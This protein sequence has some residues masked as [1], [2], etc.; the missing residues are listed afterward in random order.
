MSGVALALAL[1]PALRRHVRRARLLD[2]PE[3]R[4]PGRRVRDG[5]AAASPSAPRSRSIGREWGGELW[6]FVLAGLLAPGGAQLLFVLAVREAGPARASVIAGAAPLVAVTIAITALGRAAAKL[7]LVAGAVLIVAGGLA[8]I[9]ERDCARSV[10]GDRARLRVR[11]RRALRDAR[12][13]R[14]P[15]RADTTVAPQLA[16]SATILSGHGAD[17]RS[18]C[19]SRAGRGSSPTSAREGPPF[20]L[21]GLLWGASYAFLFEAFY[22]SRVIGRQP[23][24]RDGV[25]VR[26]P[27]RGAAPAPHGARRPAPDRS[28]RRWSSPAAR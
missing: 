15:H 9:A 14:P 26:R 6:P 20:V 3:P 22:R 23:A 19:S 24:R 12:Q 11:L 21:P 7:P 8:L 1:C 17:L 10:P 18:A 25:A 2:A 27:A 4:R 5:A 28:A 13:R 16:A